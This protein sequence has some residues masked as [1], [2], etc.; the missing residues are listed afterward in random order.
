MLNPKERAMRWVDSPNFDKA[1]RAE[2]QKMLENEQRL[3]ECFGQELSFGTGG[4]RGILGAGIGR[5][6]RYTV[7]R[8]TQ[9][10][11]IFIGEDG[12]AVAIGYDTR[13][14]SREFAEVTAG[15]LAKNG[16]KAYLFDRPLPT[17][18]LS[19]AVRELG[20]AAGVMIT[21]SHNPAEYNGYKVYGADGCQITDG[22]AREITEH[23]ERIEYEM[24][25]WLSLEEAY[26]KELL[27]D[28]PEQIYRSYLSHTLNGR[29]FPAGEAIPLK[30]VYSA[31][32]G[33]GIEPVDEILKLMPGV[34][35]V[36]VEE[37]C[38]HNGDFPTCP[39]PNPELP[40][41]LALSL[42]IA[43]REEA[44]LLL[45]TDPD[46]DRVG[47][48]IRM[49][50]GMYKILT[51]NEVG[52]L[53]LEYILKSRTQSGTLPQDPLII[54]TIVTS[55]L[56]F[57]I[58]QD[59]GAEVAEVL[60]GFKY[61]GERIG[62]L[63]AVGK[64]DRYVFGFEESCGYLA[65]NHVRDKDGVMA[66]ML[67]TEMAQQ[68]KACGTT[69]EHILEK[70]Y[71]TYGVMENRLE[72]YEIAGVLAMETMHATMR[73][74]R[75]QPPVQLA[76]SPITTS[77]DYLLGIDGLPSSDVLSYATDSGAKAIVRPSGTEP[78]VKVYL[79]VRAQTQSAAHSLVEQMARETG[80]WL[81][82]ENA[83]H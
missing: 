38:S 12:G 52:I 39:R 18:V 64:E 8:A 53:L 70:L 19:F 13:N 36:R 15:V 61:I 65:G 54:K 11:A 80:E 22:V 66:C 40:E 60:T 44:D 73:H 83:S 35:M 27:Q 41:G 5:M 25:C 67:V 47:V 20:C 75:E 59:Y 77:K 14:G 57:P 71:S 62:Q 63:E 43:K 1:T 81:G 55:D 34:T 4:L 58:A 6:N 68:A 3:L 46:C 10:L 30:V 37:Q 7:A 21:A 50:T 51:G 78:K 32:C 28:V 16:L 24:P 26:Q 17:P 56:A 69:I 82:F 31:L 76:G 79:S 48:A 2:V 33:T 42:E 49:G 29:L 74:L 23:M 45:A 72:S 9:G